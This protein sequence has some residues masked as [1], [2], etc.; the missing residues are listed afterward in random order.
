[1]VVAIT[2]SRATGEGEDGERGRA[3]RGCRAPDVPARRRTRRFR[4]KAEARNLGL[5]AAAEKTDERDRH[6][7]LAGRLARIVL[8]GRCR[9]MG[10]CERH[11][12]D[13]KGK[14]KE[15]ERRR[16]ATATRTDTALYRKWQR[17]HIA[18]RASTRL[19]FGLQPRGQLLLNVKLRAGQQVKNVAHRAQRLAFW[20]D[21]LLHDP[22]AQGTVAWREN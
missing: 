22:H 21:K 8:I 6:L 2:K 9:E 14:I 5:R 7:L 17:A 15:K 16:R 4:Q 11:E 20:L 1:M 10:Q 3:K 18:P 12:C 13:G 19:T